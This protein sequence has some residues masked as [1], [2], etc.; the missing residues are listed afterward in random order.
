M[1]RENPYDRIM[2]KVGLRVERVSDSIGKSF[3]NMKPF[4]QDVI[5]ERDLMDS[6][7]MLT[8]DDMFQLIQTHGEQVVNDFIGEMERKRGGFNDFR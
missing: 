1:P 7:N 2:D 5:P 8:P 4:D 6:Y 3:R